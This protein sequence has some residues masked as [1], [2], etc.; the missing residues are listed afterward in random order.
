M[1][2]FFVGIFLLIGL[3]CSAQMQKVVFEVLNPIYEI[4]PDLVSIKV[5][6]V[7]VNKVRVD[8]T[9]FSV[10]LYRGKYSIVLTYVGFS[11]IE[12]TIYLLNDVKVQCEFKSQANSLEEVTISQNRL[13][14][15]DR[16]IIGL[17]KISIKELSKIPVLMGEIDIQ[18]GLQTLPGVSSVGEGAN[19]LNIRGGSSDQNLL[20]LEGTPIY[21]PTHIFGLFSVVPSEAI[22]SIELYKG[23]IPTR[24]GGRI[25][26]VI[27]LRS[28]EPSLNQ[29]VIQG[30]FGLIA[31]KL[32]I[33][34]PIIKD[35]MS[36]MLATRASFTGSLLKNFKTLKKFDGGFKELFGK[37]VLKPNNSNKISL[38]FFGTTDYT[39]FVG[40]ALNPEG[41]NSEDTEVSYKIAN[42]SLRWIHAFKKERIYTNLLITNSVFSPQLESPDP[43]LTITVSNQI[44]NQ[45]IAYE[46]VKGLRKDDQLEFG[47]ESQLNQI[48]PGNYYQNKELVRYLPLEKSLESALYGSYQVAL[49]QRLKSDIGVRYSLFHNLGKATYREYLNST[50]PTE[51]TVILQKT[52]ANNTIYNTYGG[53]EPRVSL[54]YLL[55]SQSSI[56]ANYT[57]SRQ[58]I[59]I[60]ANNT[61]PLPV[62]RWKTSD[63]HLKPQI[64]SMYSAGYYLNLTEKST[65]FSTEL[66]FRQTQNFTDV[67]MGSDFLLKDYVE[68]ELL[69]GLNRAY[70]I[71]AMFSKQFNKSVLTFNYTYSRSYNKMDGATIFS[72]INQ[73]D[74]YRSNFDRPHAF[75]A[76]FKIQESSIHHFSFAFTFASGR[77][78]TAP[79]GLIRLEN[80]AFPIY[81]NRNNA[82]IPAYH[83]LDFSWTIDNPARKKGKYRGSWAFNVYNLYARKNI[84][85][86]F[87][88]NKIGSVKSFS[89]SVFAT[90]IPSISY[91]FIIK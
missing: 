39:Q 36:V 66:Y 53:L 49:S 14:D 25:A 79:E 78:F 57:V 29:T 68:T 41:N 40:V 91:N 83:R 9:R 51:E 44:K 73:G 90:A 11:P 88:S 69:Q 62:S 85:S 46:L 81:K 89:I 10:S 22:G 24:Y 18:R 1:K 52:A 37:L 54:A 13:T 61:T 32:S 71:E 58:Y 48:Q 72:Q 27:D 55:N 35:K 20:L 5:D 82:R 64:S 87:F 47:I 12:K 74:W 86:V 26:S 70:G 34:T 56:K 65:N 45:K 84:Y 4:N 43:T 80:K 8:S 16:P 63:T 7:P 30:G 59:Q 67:K 23:A 31:S 75:N 19:G 33:E 76:N 3:A 15:I 77:P 17:Q 42:F 2:G 60:I 6:N 21:N 50:E 38:N 28:K